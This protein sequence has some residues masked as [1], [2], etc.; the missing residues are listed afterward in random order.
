MAS[1]DDI[2]KRYSLAGF[3]RRHAFN[4]KTVSITDIELGCRK[5]EELEPRDSMYRVSTFLV[6]EWWS[7]PARLVE[8][9]SVLLRCGIPTSTG[10][11]V[12]I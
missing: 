5:F 4:P 11:V 10:L 7:A 1:N 6:R 3:L 12:R 8:A 9:L 2:L